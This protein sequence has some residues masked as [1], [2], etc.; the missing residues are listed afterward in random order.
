MTSTPSQSTGENVD[1]LTVD[2]LAELA[3]EIVIYCRSGLFDRYSTGHH[4]TLADMSH[5]VGH[6]EEFGEANELENDIA[7]AADCVYDD[8][9]W[10]LG[11]LIGVALTRDRPLDWGDIADMVCNAAQSAGRSISNEVTELQRRVDDY[12]AQDAVA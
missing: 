8:Y 2:Q 10:K 9:T 12:L 5:K 1:W 4:F 6:H 11:L 3:D 7:F